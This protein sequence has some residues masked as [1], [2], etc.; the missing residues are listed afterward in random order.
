MKKYLI[1]TFILLT[2]LLITQLAFAQK[3]LSQKLSGSIL[4]QVQ[5]HGQAWYVN[6]ANYRKYYLGR[7]VDAF[8]LMRNLGIGITNED[9]NKIPVGIIKYNYQDDD[10]DG[11]SNS[12][13]NA[14]GT[15][16]QN[17]DSDSDGY[18]DKTE[19][20]NNYDPL[21][22][23]KLIIDEN[24]TRENL[25]KIFLQTEK[26]GQAW[27]INPAD[28]KKYFLGR[29]ADA[30]VIMKNLSLGITN[31]NLNK[32]A[33]GYYTAPSPLPP[34][35]TCTNCQTHSAD[36]VFA[37]A[38]SAIRSGD[39]IT[40]LTYFTPEMQKAIEYTMDFLNDEGRFILGNIMSGAKLS[41]STDTEKTYSAE[42]YFSLGGYKVPIYFHIKKQGDGTWL[43]ANL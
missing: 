12:L 20:E 11:L 27:Y 24:F 19:V 35:T 30:F 29:P 38:A 23:G 4:L 17:I 21:N 41:D 5:S 32:I 26:A 10:N 15:D 36:Q 22:D 3:N 40:T 33:T 31:A 16:P 42:V 43:L 6:P 2:T 8:A 18:D 39:K 25:G 14:L 9:L 34:P 13:E 7:P 1:T 37:A 28:G